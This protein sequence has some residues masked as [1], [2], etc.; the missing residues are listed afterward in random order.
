[1]LHPAG[2]VVLARVDHTNRLGF[3]R[4]R[5]LAFP[6]RFRIINVAV[7]SLSAK[8]YRIGD[9]KHHPFDVRERD[10]SLIAPQKIDSPSVKFDVASNGMSA[11]GSARTMVWGIG[12][13]NR[14]ARN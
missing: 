1:M 10:A 3:C 4:C 9:A 2:P 11:F 13:N 8:A 14:S 5:Q 12:R 7:E 6:P